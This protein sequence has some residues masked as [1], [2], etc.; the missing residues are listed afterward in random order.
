M[1]SWRIFDNNTLSSVTPEC[2]N[3]KSKLIDIKNEKNAPGQH[4][5][6]CNCFKGGNNAMK[7]ACPTKSIS[8]YFKPSCNICLKLK[9]K[10]SQQNKE[11]VK[12][13]SVY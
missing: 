7:R 2:Q 8:C 11:K 1:K 4:L 6:A 9:K 5:K 10:F 3:W 13:I 12:N